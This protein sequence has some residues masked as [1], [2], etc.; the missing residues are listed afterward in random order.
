V[1]LVEDHKL[2]GALLEGFALGKG[3]KDAAT[4]EEA[5]SDRCGRLL[6]VVWGLKTHLVACNGLE[7]VGTFGGEL[8]TDDMPTVRVRV[9]D[10]TGKDHT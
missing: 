1:F 3:E 7:M 6:E 4:V 10:E 2:K 9:L 5:Q 8:T